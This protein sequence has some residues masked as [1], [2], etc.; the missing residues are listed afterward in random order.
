MRNS[1]FALKQNVLGRNLTANDP[2]Q[3]FVASEGEDDPEVEF[4]K[5]LTTK[6]KQKLLRKLDRLEKKKKKKKDRKKKKQQKRKSKSKH[7]KHKSRC[8]ST[9]SSE[10]SVSSSS[11]ETDSPDKVAQKKTDSKGKRKGKFSEASSSDS[12]GEAKTKGKLYRK[13][14]SSHGNKDKGSASVR[15]GCRLRV[16]AVSLV[17]VWFEWKGISCQLVVLF[18]LL[19]YETGKP[20]G[21]PDTPLPCHNSLGATP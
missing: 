15:G 17:C 19:C 11:E 2:S 13:R 21:S 1:G 7:R 16:P 14:S 18:I 10:S 5:S 20:C 4:L 3:E 8:S 6:Q 12:E 9:S